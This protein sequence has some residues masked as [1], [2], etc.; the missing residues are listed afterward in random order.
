MPAGWGR[1]IPR[2]YDGRI[3]RRVKNLEKHAYVEKVLPIDSV[4]EYFEHFPVLEIDFTFYRLLL[5]EQGRPTTNYELLKTY[6][7]YRKADDRLI[8]K[9]PQTIMAQKLR[10]GKSYIRMPII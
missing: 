3:T 10:Q 2:I 4:V 9:V 5:N 8:L 7:R 6:K 1:F